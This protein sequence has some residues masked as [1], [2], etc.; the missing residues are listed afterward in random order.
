[1]VAHMMFS[2]PN[3]ETTRLSINDNPKILTHPI[4]LFS[5]RE[6]AFVEKN[7]LV[8]VCLFFICFDSSKDK[9]PPLSLTILSIILVR[10]FV[11]LLL[12][13][14]SPSPTRIV[15]VANTNPSNEAIAAKT[16]LLAIIKLFVRSAPIPLKLNLITKK[17]IAAITKAINVS[18]HL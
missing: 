4:K 13:K 3:I 6:Y 11:L 17:I 1:M 15:T 12:L 14:L 16:V 5:V 2:L 9:S 7:K 18:N 10:R 8:A